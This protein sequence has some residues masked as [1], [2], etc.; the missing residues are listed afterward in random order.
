MALMVYAMTK[1]V[2]QTAAEIAAESGRPGKRPICVFGIGDRAWALNHVAPTEHFEGLLT[3]FDK[4]AASFEMTGQ[5][6]GA[7]LELPRRARVISETNVFARHLQ[8]D[9]DGRR[10]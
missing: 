6:G 1:A 3:L 7:R 2:G 4:S 9:G 8:E 10:D 5:S